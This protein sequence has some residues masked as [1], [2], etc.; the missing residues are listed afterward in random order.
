MLQI[1]RLSES[2]LQ[3]LESIE[4]SCFSSPWNQSQIIHQLTHRNRISLG[5]FHGSAL[6]GFAFFSFI[7]DEAEL[8]QIAID[9]RQRGLGAAKKLLSE[10]MALLNERS[11]ARLFLEVRA[12]NDPAIALYR[13]L[14][15][16]DDGCR[17]AYYPAE[18]EGGSREDALLMSRDL[19]L[20]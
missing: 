1:R 15:F 16:L 2:D 17:K 18:V 3:D 12:S 11:I 13:C 9:P 4:A 6:L 7:L 20:P 19:T 5:V 8:L 10:A 14:G